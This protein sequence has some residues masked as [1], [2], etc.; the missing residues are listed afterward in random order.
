MNDLHAALQFYKA[1]AWASGGMYSD[2]LFPPEKWCDTE[3]DPGSWVGV[4]TYQGMWIVLHSSHF[5][6]SFPLF[7]LLYFPPVT[8]FPLPVSLCL[9]TP[10]LLLQVKSPIFMWHLLRMR[11]RKVTAEV[12]NNNHSLNETAAPRSSPWFFSSHASSCC[13]SIT[14]KGFPT[15]GP[16]LDAWELYNSTSNWTS[17]LENYSCWI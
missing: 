11:C 6:P 2:W 7:L 3:L 14:S 17:E 9:Q 4:G 8:K 5:P 15:R 16:E 12:V 13:A 1:P 10:S